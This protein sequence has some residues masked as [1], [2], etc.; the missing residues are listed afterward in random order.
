MSQGS[1][2]IM[3]QKNTEHLKKEQLKEE[4]F[5]KYG[6]KSDEL[7]ML[8]IYIKHQNKASYVT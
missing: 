4:L 6:G 5:K 1:K 3:E 7:S 2:A 8:D